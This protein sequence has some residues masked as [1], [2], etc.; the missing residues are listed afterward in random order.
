MLANLLDVFNERDAARRDAAILRTYA[1]D[2]RWTD[3]K[4][5][6][7]AVHGWPRNALSCRQ[8][9]ETLSSF[10]RDRSISFLASTTR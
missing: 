4:A 3:G 9:W 10:P 5:S 2:V 7:K 6:S 1:D 8:E